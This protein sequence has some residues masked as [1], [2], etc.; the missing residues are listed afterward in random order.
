M[1]RDD[2]LKDFISILVQ[3]RKELGFT[4]DDVNYKLGVA[5]AS[6]SKW[7]CGYRTPTPF[8]LYCWAQVLQAK[9]S[10]IKEEDISNEE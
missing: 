7:E 6:V 2:F 10:I 5:D 8:N 4:Q 1:S 3:R 9:L